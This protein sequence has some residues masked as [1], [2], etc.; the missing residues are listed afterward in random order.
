MK[1]EYKK[2][3]AKVIDFSYDDQ[4]VADSNPPPLGSEAR[5]DNDYYCQYKKEELHCMIMVSNSIGC[6]NALWSLRNFGR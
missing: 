1:R 5:P 4:V 2:P 6:E 3:N